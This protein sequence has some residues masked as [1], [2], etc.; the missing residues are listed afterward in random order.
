VLNKLKVFLLVQV[1]TLKA[2]RW[3]WFVLSLFVASRLIVLTALTAA[4]HQIARSDRY[5]WDTATWTRPFA[6]W[7]GGWYLSIA[8]R[9]YHYEA[10]STEYQTVAFFPLYPLLMHLFSGEHFTADMAGIIISNLSL[11]VALLY[12]YP[13]VRH[14]SSVKATRIAT[15]LLAFSPYSLFASVLYSEGLFLAL[16]AAFLYYL[17]KKKWLTAGLLAGL[18][19]GVRVTGAFL[20]IPLIAAV[21]TDAWTRKKLTWRMISSLVVSEGGLLAYM[22]FLQTAFGDPL[23]FFKVQ[24]SWERHFFDSAAL[25]KTFV[26]EFTSGAG[27][28]RTSW[29][30]LS[31]ILDV[32][33]LV[34]A[35]ALLILGLFLKLGREKLF[36]SGSLLLLYLVSSSNS[37]T[38]MGRLIFVILPLYEVGARLLDRK[39]LRWSVYPLMLLFAAGLYLFSMLFAQW[40]W[41]D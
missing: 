37:F 39:Y 13:L 23:A 25:M 15:A 16:L 9:G 11:L 12:F 30:L 10:G 38:G 28:W 19:S 36:L 31:R 8:D 35:L 33:M 3:L 5:D 26:T 32:W 14:S 27:L 2:N 17:Q 40:Y 6:R 24:T 20:V 4:P 18:S 34:T 29:T 21:V 7:D 22:V 1:A 41:V